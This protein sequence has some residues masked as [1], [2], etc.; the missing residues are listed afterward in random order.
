[1]CTKRYLAVLNLLL[2]LLSLCGCSKKAAQ[3]ATAANSNNATAATQPAT[4]AAARAAAANSAPAASAAT[5]NNTAPEGAASDPA[6]VAAADNTRP[7]A[8]AGNTAQAAPETSPQLVIPAGT[9]ITVR[10]QQSLSS[11]SAVRGERFEAVVDQPIVVGDRIVVP[12][13]AL[14]T[15]HVV[16]A[17]RSGRL[18]HPGELG[19]TLD[20]VNVGQQNIPIAT[21]SFVAHGASHK[22]RNLGWIGGGTG[23]GAL[24]GALAAG[25]KGALIGGGIGAA[26]GTTTAIVT[27]KKDVVFGSERRLSFRLNRDTS[28]S[29]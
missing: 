14:A 9:S 25:G 28:L 12:T 16:V 1:M 29:G 22:K 4:D 6:Q 2:V 23:G 7:V 10:L 5:A 15:G 18:H 19:L 13:G 11:A 3:N 17:R 20:S 26:A 24:I 21:S 8:T 27:G